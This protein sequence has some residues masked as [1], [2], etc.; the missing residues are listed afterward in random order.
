MNNFFSLDGKFYKICTYIGDLIILAIM[1]AIACLP[2]ITI[3]ASTTAFYYV[4][5]RQLSDREG[6]VTHDFFKSFKSNFVEATIVTVV[7]MLLLGGVH[8]ILSNT[9]KTSVIFWA[10]FIILYELFITAT[11]IFPVLSRFDLKLIQLFKKAFQLA[12]LHLL[13][14]ITLVVLFCAILWL[15]Y[16]KP[17]LIVMLAGV[18]GALSSMIF[19]RIFKKYIPDM[20]ADEEDE[21]EV[22]DDISDII[23]R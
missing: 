23:T 2:I 5:T 14:T 12:N 7:F 10:Q 20:D 1:W 8:L 18:Y 4:A 11:W 15:C 3:G 21:F 16:K 22:E 13:S 19:M 17:L 6:Y 9:D